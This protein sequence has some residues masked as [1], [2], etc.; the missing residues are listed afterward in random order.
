[1]DHDTYLANIQRYAD[2]SEANI[3]L[4]T[5]RPGPN[6]ERKILEQARSLEFCNLWQRRHPDAAPFDEYYGLYN[7][8]LEAWVHMHIK[9][10]EDPQP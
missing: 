1:M 9:L 6:S 8:F 2:I 4:F 10:V 7:E 3:I 5:G